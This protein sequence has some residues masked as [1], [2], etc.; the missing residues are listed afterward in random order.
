MSNEPR[1]STYFGQQ[2]AE[3]AQ[4]QKG[5]FAARERAQINGTAPTV[6]VPGE[7]AVWQTQWPDAPDPLGYAIDEVPDMERGQ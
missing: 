6:T 1:A 2:L 7:L 3:E 5:R 4:A